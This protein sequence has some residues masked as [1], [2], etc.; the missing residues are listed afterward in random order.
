MHTGLGLLSPCMDQALLHRDPEPLL[1]SISQGIVFYPKL[2][3]LT[4]DR[5]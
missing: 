5:T 3:Q 4:P 2:L 1:P